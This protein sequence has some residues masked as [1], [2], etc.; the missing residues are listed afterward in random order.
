[1]YID[2]LKQRTGLE[3]KLSMPEDFGRLPK[4]IELIM[5]RMVQESLT[6]VLRHSGA[7]SCEIQIDRTAQRVTLEIRDDGKGISE[8]KLA[9]INEG[10]SGVGIRGMRDRVRHLNG[11]LH[12]R[13]TG[14]GTTIS[15]ALPLQANAPAE[16]DAEPDFTNA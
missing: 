14:A 12:V 11:E 1:M 8:E 13:S 4:E 2:G 7:K 10:R 3:I 9:A 5:F 15:I 16:R 6:N